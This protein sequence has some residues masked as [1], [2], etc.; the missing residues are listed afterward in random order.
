MQINK[1]T[2]KLQS[3]Y[4]VHQ[5]DFRFGP[6]NAVVLVVLATIAAIIY[7][8]IATDTLRGILAT[9]LFALAIASILRYVAVWEVYSQAT[10][11]RPG[12]QPEHSQ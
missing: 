10:C 11:C 7:A 9:I 2:L 8:S 1:S 6:V 4:G 12:D 5:T 3:K